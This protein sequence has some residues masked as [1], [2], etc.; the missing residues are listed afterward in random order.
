M[1]LSYPTV[2]P[3]GVSGYLREAKKRERGCY[4]LITTG[5]TVLME[6]KNGAIYPSLFPKLA[7]IFRGLLSSIALYIQQPLALYND[8]GQERVSGAKGCC[9]SNQSPPIFY[10]YPPNLSGGSLAGCFLNIV[11]HYVYGAIIGI[12]S[13][14]SRGVLDIIAKAQLL[15]CRAGSSTLLKAW[16]PKA[17]SWSALKQT[18]FPISMHF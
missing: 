1:Q 3:C 6:T 12:D 9:V 10:P 2:W 7:F 15:V 11:R 16:G 5:K 17:N 8:T 13:S 18:A 14:K 4:Q